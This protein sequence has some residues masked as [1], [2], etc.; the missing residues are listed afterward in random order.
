M[1]VTSLKT[2]STLASE[3][4]VRPCF[5]SPTCSPSPRQD[6]LSRRERRSAGLVGCGTTYHGDGL[7]RH[8]TQLGEDGEHVQKR[9]GR[10]L[11]SAVQT[12]YHTH[13]PAPHNSCHQARAHRGRPPLTQS[14]HPSPALMTGFL[15]AAAASA[16]LPLTGWRRTVQKGAKHWQ[17]SEDRPMCDADKT[18]ICVLR[19]ALTDCVAVA[20]HAADGV[21]QRLSLL[22]AGRALVDVDHRPTQPLKDPSNHSRTTDSDTVRPR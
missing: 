10:V 11:A 22:G 2:P 18:H 19:R 17:L 14:T 15:L 5:R 3:C 7:A 21:G 16:A 12:K 13:T 8:T 6:G 1:M 4:T 20:R 9:L